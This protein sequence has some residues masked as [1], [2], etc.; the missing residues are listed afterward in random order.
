MECWGG[1][2][3]PLSTKRSGCSLELRSNAELNI[4]LR[5]P[6]PRLR[7]HGSDRAETAD[8]L[9]ALIHEG[10]FEATENLADD[11]AQYTQ[12]GHAAA[13]TRPRCFAAAI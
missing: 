7:L 5:R 11:C 3:E 4:A 8:A 13:T 10:R 12:T 1:A 2:C 6:A 9:V